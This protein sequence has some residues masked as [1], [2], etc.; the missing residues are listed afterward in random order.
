MKKQAQTTLNIIIGVVLIG[1]GVA[2][3]FNYSGLGALIA[4]IGILAE[5]AIN[6][7]KNLK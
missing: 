3:L 6:F 2:Y 5:I 1:G 7:A 4:G